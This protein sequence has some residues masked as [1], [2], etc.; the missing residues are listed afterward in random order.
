MDRPPIRDAA[1]VFEANR[2]IAV[3]PTTQV[4]Q[5]YPDAIIEDLGNVILMPGLVNAHTHLELS[6]CLCT[7]SPAGEFTAWLAAMIQRHKLEP[8]ELS[9]KVIWAVAQGVEQCLRF[10]VTTVGDISRM[11]DITRPLLAFCPLRVVSY[12]EVQAMAQ[13]RHLLED[14][15][16]AAIDTADATSRLIIGLSPHAPYSVELHGYRRCLEI[17]KDQS[18]PLATHLAE[19]IAEADFLAD[20]S[21]PFRQ[22]WDDLLGWDQNVPRFPGGPIRFAQSTGLLSHPTL[23]AHV[24]YCNDDEM[25]IL[26]RGKASVVYCP[27]THAHFQHPPHRWREMLKAGINVA[28]GTDSCTVLQISISWTTFA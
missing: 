17:A 11:C 2:I 19:S 10:G 21:G 5:A 14:R 1:L 23:L 4:A 7:S 28:I 6:D 27:R 26:A 25:A 16:M 13:R 22:L 3:G 24:N 8:A 9:S 12:G 18:L 20:H 15:L